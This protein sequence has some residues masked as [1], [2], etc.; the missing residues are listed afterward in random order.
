MKGLFAWQSLQQSCTHSILAGI[1]VDLYLL[2]RVRLE[3]LEYWGS[4]HCSPQLLK[5]FLAL[6]ITLKDYILLCKPSQWQ[7]Y[8]R[9]PFDELPKELDKL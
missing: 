3:D 4:C 8:C 2:R 1:F 7:F 5:G 6:L 9:E